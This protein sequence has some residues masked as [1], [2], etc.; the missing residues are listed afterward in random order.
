MPAPLRIHLSPEE[1]AQLR[2]L[3]TNP[4]VPHKVRRRAQ[5]VRLAAQGWTAPASPAIW[6]WTAPLLA[7]TLEGRFFTRFHP[8]TVRRRLL[9]LGYRWGRTRY[10]PVETVWR[11]VKGWL[12]PWRYYGSME[13]LRRG[14]EEALRKQRERLEREGGQSLCV[15]R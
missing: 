12:L 13:E 11:R 5:A 6:A 14:V 3:E 1:D 10:V 8:G 15:A 4:V 7:E 2:E 9:A